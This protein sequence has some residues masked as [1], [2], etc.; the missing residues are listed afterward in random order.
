[1]QVFVDSPDSLLASLLSA[2][3]TGKLILVTGKTGSGK[4][5][6]CM[7]LAEQAKAGGFNAVGLISP[8]VFDRDIKTGIDL[9]DVESGSKQRLAVRRGK[10]GEGQFTV[11]WDFN[12]EVLNWGNLILGQL[13]TS[14]LLILDEMGPLELDQGVGLV[15]GIGLISARRYG[16]ACV[17]VRPSLLEIARTLWPWGVVSHVRTNDPTEVSA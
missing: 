17:V 12:E 8:A 4:T 2:N 3:E 7:D 11:G 5:R 1:M 15:N 16:L 10:S 13:E 6:W 14:Q 9:V